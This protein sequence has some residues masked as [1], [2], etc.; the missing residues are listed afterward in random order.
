MRSWAI[1]GLGSIAAAILVASPGVSAKTAKEGPPPPQVSALLAC[2][3][4]GDDA[5]AAGLL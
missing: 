3:S 4:I 1:V 2:R 5:A